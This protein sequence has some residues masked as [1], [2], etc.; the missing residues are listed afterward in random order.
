[1]GVAIER[2]HTTL[3]KGLLSH[4]LRTNEPPPEIV[5]SPSLAVKESRSLQ[6]ATPA[7][8]ARKQQKRLDNL[9]VWLVLEGN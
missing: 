3:A 9:V 4:A 2:G 1:M 8:I 6:D 7:P 5:T